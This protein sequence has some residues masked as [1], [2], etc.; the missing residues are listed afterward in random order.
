MTV[1][2]SYTTFKYSNLTISPSVVKAGQNVSIEVAVENT[3]SRLSDEV[4]LKLEIS[5]VI[6]ILDTCIIGYSSIYFMVKHS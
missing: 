5:L 1:C 2:R 6:I 3:G 4:L